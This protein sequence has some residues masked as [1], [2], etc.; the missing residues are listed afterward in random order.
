M[1]FQSIEITR[2]GHVATLWLNRP[3][4]ANAMDAAF[5]RELPEAAQTLGDDPGVRCIVV[6]GRGKYFT[7]G[8]DLAMLDG[9]QAETQHSDPARASEKLRRRIMVL[10]DTFTA[11]ERCE[12]PVIA[13]IHN[14]CIGGGIDLITACDIRY[15]SADAQFCVKEVDVGLAADVGTL[16][17]LPRIVGEGVAREWALTAR[18]VSA[19]EAKEARLVNQV[20]ATQ[21]ALMAH[22]METARL[23][24]SKS[25]IAIR[26]TKQVL[27]YSRDHSVAEG[28]AQVANW[29]ASALITADI[30][31]GIA[32][33]K[34]RRAAVFQ[35]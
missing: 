29:N 25:P 34:Q 30:A 10:Q 11:L 3:A 13:A 32:A 18:M 12:K 26:G 6:A 20:F 19:A 27:N 21:E 2:E 22:A 4:Q 35:D 16:Q 28:L 7:A 23:I 14:L 33:A 24:A 17:R 1:S 9:M 8:I 5:W 31:E 15:C